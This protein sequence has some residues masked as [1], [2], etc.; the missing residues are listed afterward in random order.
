MALEVKTYREVRNQMQPGDVIA[1]GGKSAFSGVIKWFTNSPVSHVAIVMHTQLLDPDG[2]ETRYFNQIIESTVKEDKSG[3]IISRLSRA[4]E[5]YDGEIWWLPLDSRV[6]QNLNKRKFFD[7][8][9][10]KEGR[11]YDTAQLLPAAL[12]FLGSLSETH[13]DYGKLFCSELVAGALKASG[14]IPETVN[15][16]EVTPHDLVTWD[17]FADT[18]IQLKGGQTEIDGFRTK[19]VTSS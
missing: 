6:R 19:P 17:I 4:W 7:W 14:A 12:D 1:F 11:P 2:E 8:L 10:D 9:M 18:Y 16:S 5:H 13:E 15:S 3:V